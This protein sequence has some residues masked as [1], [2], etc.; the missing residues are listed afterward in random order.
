MVLL[1]Q[2]G[3]SVEGNQV[4][5]NLSMGDAGSKSYLLPSSENGHGS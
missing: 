1:F 2:W 5:L 4:M 3:D